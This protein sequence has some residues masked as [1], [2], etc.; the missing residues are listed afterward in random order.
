MRIGWIGWSPLRLLLLVMMMVGSASAMDAQSGPKPG[1]VVAP[2]DGELGFLMRN[3]EA[4]ALSDAQIQQM[5]AVAQRL[6]RQNEPLIRRLH[7][8]GIPTGLAERRRLG[9]LSPGERE[10]LRAA[11]EANR[12]VFQELRQNTRTAVREIRGV[13][14]PE[15]ATKVRRLMHERQRQRPA[16]REGRNRRPPHRGTPPPR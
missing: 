3:R 14:T 2:G 11:M 10:E 5:G 6:Q 7:S 9:R 16:P 12:P 13:L 15:Q 8:A 4:L 1:R